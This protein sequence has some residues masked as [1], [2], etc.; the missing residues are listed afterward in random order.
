MD[1]GHL[2]EDVVHVLAYLNDGIGG[3]LDAIV[4]KAL[5]PDP[6]LRYRSADQMADDLR[7]HM[8]FETISARPGTWAYRTSLFARRHRWPLC[9]RLS[10][11]ASP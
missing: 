2:R 3:D 4:Q 11:S 7:R 8:A 10:T 6:A 5:A 9:W 1:H